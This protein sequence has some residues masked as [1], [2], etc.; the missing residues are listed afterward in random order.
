MTIQR[1]VNLGESDV[2]AL[3]KGLRVLEL[4]AEK[5]GLTSPEI[6]RRTGLNKAMVFRILR[7]LRLHGYV[8]LDAATR[9]HSLGIKLMELGTAAASRLNVVGVSRPIIDRLRDEVQETVN[10]G[11]LRD[12]QVIY[13]AMAESQRSLRMISSVGRRDCLHSTSIG[14]AM[15]AW[16]GTS[17]RRTL[18]AM[19]PLERRT[20]AT[21]TDI[22][23]LL[24][25]LDE[26]RTRGYAIDDQENEPGACCIGVPILNGTGYPIAALSVSGPS[27]RMQANRLPVVAERLWTASNAISLRLGYTELKTG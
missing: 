5:G 2:P 7:A 25:Q 10:L 22:D 11:I 3:Q 21:I 24:L 9:T 12:G 8:E 16:L 13:A 27:T 6:E 20:T 17:E 14:K 15:L 18:L 23:A 4:L 26:S 1:E 19:H